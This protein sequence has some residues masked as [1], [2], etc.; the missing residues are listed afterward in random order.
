MIPGSKLHRNNLSI[1][2]TESVVFLRV[3]DF[4]TRRWIAQENENASPSMLRGL[5]T[6]DLVKPIRISSIQIE[7]VG[8]SV[9][10]WS[11]GTRHPVVM[12]EK[13]NLFS[14]T[15][16][17]F[18]APRSHPARRALSVGPGLSHYADED[19][20]IDYR[21]PSSPSPTHDQGPAHLYHSTD[22]PRGRERIRRRLSADELTFWREPLQEVRSPS[23]TALDTQSPASSDG[24]VSVLPLNSTTDGL[25]TDAAHTSSRSTL[26]QR[27]PAISPPS[28]PVD[29]PYENRLLLHPPSMSSSLPTPSPPGSRTPPVSHLSVSA[30]PSPRS[31]H[32]DTSTPSSRRV[33]F[34]DSRENSPVRP[35]SQSRGRMGTRFSLA[36]VSSSIF[37][38]M[39]SV[40]GTSR[41][42]D[43]SKRRE[44]D[45]CYPPHHPLGNV[46][47]VI[48]LDSNEPERSGDGWQEFK[49]GTYTFPVSFAIPSYM[50]PT[51]HC[52][53]GSVTWHLKAKVHR[54]GV[55]T[56]KLSASRE[57]ILVVSP[58]E[59]NGEDREVLT[60]E[61]FWEDQL[62]YILTVSGRV[63]PIGGI[64][65][66]TLDLL[67]MAK[68][69]IYRISAQLEE[70]VDYYF[71]SSAMAWRTDVGQHVSLLSV[72]SSEKDTPILPLSQPVTS[73]TDSPLHGLIGPE[74]NPSEF[75]ANMMGPGPWTFQ[76]ALSIPSACGT[77]HSSN[78]NMRAPIK[79]SHILKVVIRVER[80]DDS[81]V[82][83]Q[84][85]KRK[86]FDIVLRMPVHIL[87]SLS[88]EQHTS[89]PRYAE[90]LNA[91]FPPPTPC[92]S[93]GSNGH[94]L[95]YQ[96]HS[97]AP[98]NSSTAD[99][100]ELQ[101]LA[102]QE[103]SPGVDAL[104][105]RNV[106]FER[107]ITGQQSEDGVV[108]PA[109]SVT[110]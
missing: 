4:S 76:M 40:S 69:R 75:T 38:V 62:Q 97:F 32:H 9:A 24:D 2:L 58:S 37:E 28:S 67:P 51:L 109:Y 52:K 17:F 16:T 13:K 48:G 31:P 59:D 102:L 21:L 3:V 61:R 46:D 96:H 14:A 86:Q 103:Q 107:L 50:P 82:D 77:L 108:P 57:V 68:V 22:P 89:L 81:Q 1:T 80:G 55:F 66:I 87:S 110:L 19:E 11:E 12:Q 15:Q 91:P 101:V 83:A 42:R 18:Q 92:A 100:L 105:E 78:K 43:Q 56:P 6:L 73:S 41:E 33:S 106:T 5:L 26:T 7:L 104:Y 53:H 71:S 8:Q 35:H 79:I 84:T 47:E 93:C 60:V 49:K 88:N 44:D 23:P 64:M 36:S 72:R 90:S 10:T 94:P 39:R 63:F 27:T 95:P 29:P 34:D 70:R 45:H 74:D 25:H 54:P 65:P 20:L 30:S 85:G 99:P 98:Q